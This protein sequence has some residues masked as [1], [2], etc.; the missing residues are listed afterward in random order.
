MNFANSIY[1]SRPLVFTLLIVMALLSLNCRFNIREIGFAEI[2]PDPYIFYY[3]HDN[4]LAENHLEVFRK[5]AGKIFNYS[6]VKIKVVN[7]ASGNDPAI[8]YLSNAESQ[9]YPVGIMVSPDGRSLPIPITDSNGKSIAYLKSII[10]SPVRSVI[11]NKLINKYAI[12][13]LLEG[14]K[15]IENHHAKKMAEKAVDELEKIMPLMP[16]QIHEG[17]ELIT[18]TREEM[19]KEKMLLWSLGVKVSQIRQPL[20]IILYGRGRMM[21]DVVEYEQ[22]QDNVLFKLL[23]IIGA[24]CECGIDRKW[25]LGKLIP[26][27]WEPRLREELFKQLEF[28]VDNPAILAEMSQIISIESGKAGTRASD[29]ELF[30]PK[31]YSLTNDLVPSDQ[32]PT[33]VHSGS[34]ADAVGEDLGYDKRLVNR[35]IYIILS[36]CLLVVIAVIG[37]FIKKKYSSDNI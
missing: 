24:D 34:E 4:N 17:P 8:N 3:F 26:L 29:L 36:V 30:Q 1:T 35:S 16:K 5:N 18:L 6:N 21:G 9:R 10:D 32:I 37:I 11:K 15:A 25:M 28:D 19:E 2:S 27:S 20:A 22:I 31:E 13:L 12:V 7:V 23:N 14:E 33:V